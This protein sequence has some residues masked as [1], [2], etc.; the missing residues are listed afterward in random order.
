[1]AAPPKKQVIAEGERALELLEDGTYSDNQV[2][3]ELSELLENVKTGALAISSE[4]KDKRRPDDWVKLVD[5]VLPLKP[6]L[7]EYR[8]NGTVVDAELVRAFS[9]TM[10]DAEKSRE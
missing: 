8:D 6:A 3:A 9:G 2:F 4:R 10:E 7:D 1:M 5:S